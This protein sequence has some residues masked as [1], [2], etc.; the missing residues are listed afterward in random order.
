MRYLFLIHIGPVQDFIASARRT[1]DLAFGSWFLSELSR[2]A[3]REIEAQN[4][5]DSLIFPA[6]AKPEMLQRNN[7]EF[8]VANKII[9]WVQQS[10]QNLGVRVQQ[11]IID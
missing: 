6:P 4:G 1:R 10:P 11:V 3:A 5:L 2:A 9:A 7:Q 8:L